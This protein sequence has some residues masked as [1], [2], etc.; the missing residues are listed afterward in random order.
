MHDE[1]PDKVRKQVKQS[2]YHKETR[3]HLT[4]SSGGSVIDSAAVLTT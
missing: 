3:H 2:R 1:W 4:A